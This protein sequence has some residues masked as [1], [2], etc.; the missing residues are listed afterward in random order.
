MRRSQ[1]LRRE[2]FRVHL[3]NTSRQ[4]RLSHRRVVLDRTSRGPQDRKQT[5]PSKDSGAFGHPSF[6]LAF[7]ISLRLSKKKEN[8]LNQTELSLEIRPK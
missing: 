8:L 6:F 4:H 7:F 1:R 2:S 3:S 5:Y